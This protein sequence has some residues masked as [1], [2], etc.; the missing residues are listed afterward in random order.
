MGTKYSNVGFSRQRLRSLA[1][2]DSNTCRFCKT[3]HSIDI[4]GKTYFGAD[5]KV[6]RFSLKKKEVVTEPSVEM[7]P[8]VMT[9]VKPESEPTEDELK[10]PDPVVEQAAALRA[11]WAED[12]RIAAE[13]E[14]KFDW[15]AVSESLLE[16]QIIYAHP[17]GSCILIDSHGE[18]FYSPQ[19]E[20]DVSESQGH[21][22]SFR[23][24]E[25]V[26]FVR[27]AKAEGGKRAVAG[28]VRLLNPAPLSHEKEI[29]VILR[30]NGANQFFGARECGVDSCQIAIHAS[31]VLTEGE[32]D[33]GVKIF[34]N[35][36]VNELDEQK[37]FCATQ[38]EIFLPEELAPDVNEHP[39]ART[40]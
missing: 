8:P 18:Q 16:G 38:I 10:Q 20:L 23:A 28:S 29:S 24:G 37:R 9:E 4:R 6:H 7:S 27:R 2:V 19:V 13:T 33:V 17:T 39:V 3:E 32:L 15:K 5:G 34:H 11:A 22:C 12:K 14:V 1:A 21:Y 36:A 25:T 26:T 35:V 40:I 31:N 30:R